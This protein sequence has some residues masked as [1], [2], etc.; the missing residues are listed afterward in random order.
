VF[1]THIEGATP[2]STMYAR[3]LSVRQKLVNE[4]EES[5]L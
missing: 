1:N 2:V 3:R 4:I 5:W